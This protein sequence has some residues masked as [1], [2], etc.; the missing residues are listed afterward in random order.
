M[1]YLLYGSDTDKA[2]TKLH[3][4]ISGMLEKKPDASHIKMTDEAFDEALLSEAIGAMGL[5]ISKIIVEMNMVFRNKE[6]KESVMGMLKEIAE[7]ESIFVFLEG[8][9]TK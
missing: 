1:I 5:F 8:D 4:L 9:L 6:A 7:S 2:R 3:A